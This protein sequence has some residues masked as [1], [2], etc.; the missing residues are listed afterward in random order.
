MLRIQ[1]RTL[2]VLLALCSV[3]VV[4]PAGAMQPP[5]YIL[6]FPRGSIHYLSI[7]E[8]V[9]AAVALAFQRRNGARIFIAA[10]TDGE[11]ARTQSVTLSPARA[12]AARQRLIEL[13]VPADRIA[14]AVYGDSHPLVASAEGKSEPQN[15]R[16]EIV[17]H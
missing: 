4:P 9:L 5:S 7:G 14:I 10:H 3:G 11:E 12:E 17:V 8:N 15:R 16:V 6:F 2:L 1:A 13:G